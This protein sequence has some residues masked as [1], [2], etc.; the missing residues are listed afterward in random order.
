M[1]FFFSMEETGN[2]VEVKEII[3]YKTTR[4]PRKKVYK[5]QKEVIGH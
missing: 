1:K 2:K 4:R 5:I 3:V